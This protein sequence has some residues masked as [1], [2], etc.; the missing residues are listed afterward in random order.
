MENN[1]ELERAKA[2]LFKLIGNG[3]RCNICGEVK[4]CNQY[5]YICRTC[6]LGFERIEDLINHCNVDCERKS[7]VE[8]KST[9][10][11]SSPGK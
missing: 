7:L 6:A 1:S 5:N 9:N 11:T 3:S 10:C 2:L 4:Y 8:S